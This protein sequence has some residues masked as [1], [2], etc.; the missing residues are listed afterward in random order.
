MNEPYYTIA[1]LA[2]TTCDTKLTP[3]TAF[4]WS[5]DTVMVPYEQA[6]IEYADLPPLKV[7]I[8]PNDRSDDG[9]R[10]LRTA[11]PLCKRCAKELVDGK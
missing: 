10:M 5:P 8:D 6:V 3:A 2:C 9:E 11:L 1:P 4:A 7:P